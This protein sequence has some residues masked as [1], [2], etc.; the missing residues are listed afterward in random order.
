MDGR[1]GEVLTR[2]SNWRKVHWGE[3]ELERELGRAGI[4]RRDGMREGMMEGKGKRGAEMQMH[5]LS[6]GKGW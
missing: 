6:S 5:V 4:W 1:C 3:L 2:W